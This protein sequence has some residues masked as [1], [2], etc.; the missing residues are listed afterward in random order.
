MIPLKNSPI[1]PFNDRFSLVENTIM[2]SFYPKVHGVTIKQLQEKSGYS[3]ERVY[4]GLHSLERKNVV[5]GGNVGKTLVYTIDTRTLP[6]QMAFIHYAIAGKAIFTEKHPKVSK[7]LDELLSKTDVEC[8]IVFGSY[9]KGEAIKESDVDVLC[10]SDDKNLE[11]N[12]LSLR[13]KYDIKINPVEVGKTDYRN[14]KKENPELW[15]EL[16]EFGVILNG[17]DLFHHL[18][19]R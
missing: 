13:H 16:M 8:A 17:Y 11:K 12:A 18:T 5:S 19:Y 9:A 4:S 6:A 15:R 1:I 2:A 3:Y 10:I 14:I 7:A